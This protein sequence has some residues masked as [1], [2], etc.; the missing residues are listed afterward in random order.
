MPGAAG[1]VHPA[2]PRRRDHRH[3]CRPYADSW[4]PADGPARCRPEP[5]GG[6]GVARHHRGTAV[7]HGDSVVAGSAGLGPP[8]AALADHLPNADLT[9]MCRDA[10][11]LNPPARKTQL[12][13]A[14]AQRLADAATVR[15]LVVT[16]PAGTA[17][18]AESVA[19]DGPLLS[20]PSW[21]YHRP[22]Q[23]PANRLEHCG[24]IVRFDWT[25]LLMPREV[26]I[27]RHQ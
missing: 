16:G 12:L 5:A 23:T 17:E 7:T 1:R 9:R 20:A 18:L 21:A 10:G 24:L 11:L 8:C 27:A 19:R 22:M 25:N 2:V 26:G 3:A 6:A 4:R 13:D 15:R 14:L